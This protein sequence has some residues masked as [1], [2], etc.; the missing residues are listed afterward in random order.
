M[1]LVTKEDWIAEAA[2][3]FYYLEFERKLTAEEAKA[4]TSGGAAQ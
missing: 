2:A 1:A 3:L 4:L